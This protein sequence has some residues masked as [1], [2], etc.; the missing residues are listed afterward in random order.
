MPQPLPPILPALPPDPALVAAIAV[1]T[2][3]PASRVARWLAGECGVLHG[4]ALSTARGALWRPLGGVNGRAL[5]RRAENASAL[6]VAQK[7]EVA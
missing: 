4:E 1:E 5:V 3:I 2:S 7:R 6:N